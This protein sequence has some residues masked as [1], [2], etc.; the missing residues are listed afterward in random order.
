[1]VA[2]MVSLEDNTGSFQK[3]GRDLELEHLLTLKSPTKKKS[4]DKH[5]FRKERIR[6][7]K[8]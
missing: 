2:R 8:S 5:A 1:M 7:G 6:G 4:S 3:K